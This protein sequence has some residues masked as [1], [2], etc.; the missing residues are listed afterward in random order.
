[1][2]NN[3]NLARVNSLL[4]TLLEN[5]EDVIQGLIDSNFNIATV[6]PQFAPFFTVTNLVIKKETVVGDE[7]FDIVHELSKEGDVAYDKMSDAFGRSD[8]EEEIKHQAQVDKCDNEIEKLLKK[9]SNRLV[10]NLCR[11]FD[12][13]VIPEFVAD[14]DFARKTCALGDLEMDVEENFET[15][16]AMLKKRAKKMG[17]KILQ[18]EGSNIDIE[19][20]IRNRENW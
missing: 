19:N 8:K 10:D 2:A 20:A 16:K 12:V 7:L 4:H 11:S 17:I 18:C 5:D 14:S 15:F 1:M 6:L 13:I 9:L 3:P